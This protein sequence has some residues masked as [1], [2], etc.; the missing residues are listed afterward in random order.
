MR[1]VTLVLLAVLS[2]SNG[3]EFAGD[4][5]T[6]TSTLNAQIY[7]GVFGTRLDHFR[8]QDYNTVQFVSFTNNYCITEF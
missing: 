5:T 1:I 3:N 6:D 4:S 8:P 2:T 7:D